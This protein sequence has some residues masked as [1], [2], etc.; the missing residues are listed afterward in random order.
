[1]SCSSAA[2][3]RCE[4]ISKAISRQL[5]RRCMP[6]SNARSADRGC[7]M[8]IG[9]IGLGRMGGNITRRFMENGH[10]AVVYDHDPNAIRHFL[11]FLNVAVP[12]KSAKGNTWGTA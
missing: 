5:L 12:Q 8:Q 11:H 4:S 9:V 10:Q 7:H 2:G 1:M 3:A 6:R